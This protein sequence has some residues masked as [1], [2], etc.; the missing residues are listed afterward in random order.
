MGSGEKLLIFSHGGCLQRESQSLESPYKRPESVLVL[1]VTS[2]AEVLMMERTRP[3]GFWQSVTGSLRW[4]ESAREAAAREL[5][6]ETG[7]R[8]DH[9]LTDLHTVVSFPIIPPWRARYAPSVRFNREHWFV[10]E[11]PSRRTIRLNPGEHRWCRW[12]DAA[13][14]AARATSWTNRRIIREWISG[15]RTG[16]RR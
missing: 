8:G 14:A 5:R 2:G 11:L 15:C 13:D 10:L 1:V 12:M 16:R 6:E 9:L 3:R 7:L 4:G